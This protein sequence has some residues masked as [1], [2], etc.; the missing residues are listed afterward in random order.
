MGR[1][2]LPLNRDPNFF[3]TMYGSLPPT[4][5]MGAPGSLQG[6]VRASFVNAK[7]LYE[8]VS[9]RMPA[10]A[11]RAGSLPAYQYWAV[12]NFIL[13]ARGAALP[14]EGINAQNA[15]TIPIR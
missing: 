11:S 1:F 2:S 7:D 14:A 4:M 15:R 13:R 5:A 12:I 8:F 10:P 6:G 3:Y 9:Q